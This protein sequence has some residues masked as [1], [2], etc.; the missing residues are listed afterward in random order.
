MNDLDAIFYPRSVAVI[1]AS[2]SPGKWPYF[3]IKHM[4]DGGFGGEIY[5]VNP[6][7]TEIFGLRTYP[8]LEAI[9]AEVDMATIVV[10]APLIPSILKECVQ[11]EI[12]GAVILSNGFEESGMEAGAKL[13]EEITAIADGAK[14]KIIGPNSVGVGNPY[15][16][17]NATLETAFLDAS[18]GDIAVVSQS[19]GVC[20]FLLSSMVNQNL[21]VS[22][23]MSLG[24]KGNVDFADLVEYLGKHQQT[25]VITLYLEGLDDPHRLLEAAKEVVKEKPIVAYKAGEESL[26]QA[27]YSHTASLAGK[28]E[29]YQAAFSQAGIILTDDLTELID[30][31]KALAFQP[32][33]KGNRVAVLSG[34]AGPGIV[35]ATACQRYGLDLA[36]IS[37]QGKKKLGE[38]TGTPYFCENPFDMGAAPVKDFTETLHDA[39][40]ILMS[41]EGVDAIAVST[42]YHPLNVPLVESL[43]NRVGE[44]EVTKPIVSFGSSP[45]GVADEQL[46]RLEKNGVPVYPLPDRAVKALAGLIR[47]G[48]TRH[49][50]S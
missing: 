15:I 34:Q 35:A 33:P 10:Q 36:K 7:V 45:N 5:P 24:N 9:S 27:T 16:N 43:I 29:I 1:G 12:R 23:V 3:T 38:L 18:K 20:A 32:P 48:K 21:G 4:V 37:P 39:L 42:V 28:Y 44:K 11:K 8:S 41:E 49:R 50:K 40:D 25:K 6:R 31:S 14:I 30:V 2:E 17:F 13:Q 26:S 19:G 22:L 46:A 47:H